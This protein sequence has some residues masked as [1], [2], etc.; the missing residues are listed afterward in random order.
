MTG[1]DLYYRAFRAF[2]AAEAEKHSREREKI[3]DAVSAVSDAS[4]LCEYTFYECEV[5]SDW[6]IA[7]EEGLEHIEKTIE[8]QRRFIKYEG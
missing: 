5:E 4:D 6:I 3:K 1:A 2:K 7:V 8:A